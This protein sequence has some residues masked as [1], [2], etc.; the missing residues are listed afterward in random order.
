MARRESERNCPRRPQVEL[1]H[2]GFRRERVLDRKKKR[3]GRRR[4][5]GKAMLSLEKDGGENIT[6][7]NGPAQ[8]MGR[9]SRG[10]TKGG[11]GR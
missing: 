11:K 7:K 5:E 2:K 10:S 6:R 4:L 1:S 3:E 8:T 9:L